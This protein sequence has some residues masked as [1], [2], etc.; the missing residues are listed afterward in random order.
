[1]AK[2]LAANYM[3][4]SVAIINPDHPSS[5]QAVQIPQGST[6]GFEGPTQLVGSNLNHALI[7]VSGSSAAGVGAGLLFDLDLST[8]SV[9]AV[10]GPFNTGVFDNFLG[11][12]RDSSKLVVGIPE[13]GVFVLDSATNTWSV[14]APRD[15]QCH[16]KFRSGRR[17]PSHSWQ[18]IDT[19]NHG[20]VQWNRG[21]HHVRG[22]R[23]FGSGAS[24]FSSQ[25]TSLDYPCKSRRID[26]RP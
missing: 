13:E 15:R 2:L 8:F 6:L 9:K 19:T 26:L 12:S 18:R 16:S 22:C 10:F 21:D 4:S 1:M 24:S 20:Q 5:A 11:S 25:W 14:G 17:H 3:D 7:A 23:Y